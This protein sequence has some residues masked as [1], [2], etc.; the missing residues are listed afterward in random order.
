MEISSHTRMISFVPHHIKYMCIYLQS[1][2]ARILDAKR[3][4]LEVA[5]RYYELS[6]LEK[7]EFGGKR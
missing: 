7:K 5:M 1:C 6:S 2:Y 4:Y 3:R